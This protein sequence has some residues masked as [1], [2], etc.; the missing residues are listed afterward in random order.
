MTPALK[1]LRQR[2]ERALARLSSVRQAIKKHGRRA[3]CGTRRSDHRELECVDVVL[4]CGGPA[5][6]SFQLWRCLS[7][8]HFVE[9]DYGGRF[10]RVLSLSAARKHFPEYDLKGRG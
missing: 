9:L 3:S 6:M 1:E 10:R 4:T 8:G 7:C 2:E 5:S